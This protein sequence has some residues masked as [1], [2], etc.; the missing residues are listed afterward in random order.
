MICGKVLVRTYQLSTSTEAREQEKV[1]RK[2]WECVL[3]DT[4]PCDIIEISLHGAQ[5][6]AISYP[7][8]HCI[9]IIG[10]DKKI[11][12]AYKRKTYKL[13]LMRKTPIF[14]ED[15]FAL[16]QQKK[17]GKNVLRVLD[18]CKLP[19]NRVRDITL[20]VDEIDDFCIVE[21][22]QSRNV[23]VTTDT[24][25]SSV[26]GLHFTDGSHLWTITGENSGILGPLKITSESQDEVYI[27]DTKSEQVHAIN[28]MGN[29]RQSILSKEN[30]K[31]I[32]PGS[33]T[34][35]RQEL[36]LTQGPQSNLTITVFKIK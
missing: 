1:L 20:G 4:Q 7:S 31:I 21:S 19:W 5:H 18:C 27:T 26:H 24:I 25:A 29:Y 33:I 13:G 36:Y 8:N 32:S 10:R 30:G 35:Y 28:A 34:K 22:N 23:I 11:T 15:I 12:T 6:F 16:D 9:T 17:G 2:T 14:M 3:G